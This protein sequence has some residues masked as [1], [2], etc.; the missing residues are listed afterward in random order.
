VGRDEEALLRY[1]DFRR[2]SDPRAALLDFLQSSY[3]AAAKLAG[4]PRAEL[5]LPSKS[6]S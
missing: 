5:V 3:A 1:E 6:A 4:W 2:A